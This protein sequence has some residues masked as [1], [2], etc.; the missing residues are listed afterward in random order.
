MSDQLAMHADPRWETITDG[1]RASL[2]ELYEE[3]VVP[4]LEQVDEIREDAVARIIDAQGE[5]SGARRD[6]ADE[7]WRHEQTRG[8]LWRLRWERCA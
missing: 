3:Y 8:E 5:A 4:A 2:N 1:Q 6:L 7:R